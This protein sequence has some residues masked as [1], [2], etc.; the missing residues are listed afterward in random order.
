MTREGDRMADHEF[1]FRGVWLP[2]EILLALEAGKI[3]AREIILLAMVDALVTPA[4]GCWASNTYLGKR[5]GASPETVRRML[6]RLEGLGYLRRSQQKGQ[7]REIETAW[8]RLTPHKTVGG[9]PQNCGGDNKGK[10]KEDSVVFFE[11]LSTPNTDPQDTE[12]ATLLAKAVQG[13]LPGRRVNVAA[14]A[15]QVALLRREAT[16]AR[17][18]AAAQWY[19]TAIGG[20]WVPQAY[21]AKT[22]REKFPAIEAAMER[23]AVREPAA[24][25]VG[26]RATGVLRRLEGL[27]W[28]KGSGPQVPQA[29][30]LSLDRFTAWQAARDR[31]TEDQRAAACIRA[32]KF[33]EYLQGTTPAPGAYVE[34]WFRRVHG[35]VQNWAGWSG[36]LS[37]MAWHMGHD[38]FQR[39]GRGWAED[40][41]GQPARW[42]AFHKLLAAEVGRADQEN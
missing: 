22:F 20:Q 36:R 41:C 17:V 14:W 6:A 27:S 1:Q 39:V 24:L 3:N 26:A 10:T 23:A 7:R 4:R 38:E 37:G 9:S 28:P 21:S 33:G 40:Y 34:A 25:V 29:V 32:Y 15:K 13:K 5:L 11:D 18:L 12:I 16:P 19:A 35:M 31:V 42:D 30:Q 2:A 8:S